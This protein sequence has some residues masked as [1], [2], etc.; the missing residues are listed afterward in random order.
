LILWF[1]G[2]ACLMV[3]FVFRE[4][5]IDYRLVIAGALLPD[6]VDGVWGGARL[7]HTLVFSVVLMFAVMAATRGRSARVRRRRR[8]WLAV[9][10]GTFLHL[11]LDGMWVRTHVFWWPFFGWSFEGARLPTLD[12]PVWV[13]ALQEA[14]GL[15]ALVWYVGQRR[16]ALADASVEPPEAPSC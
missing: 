11:V 2:G 16:A 1:A 14:A 4:P 9:P 6:L 5:R 10:I 15:A 13:V 3:W 12:R 8:Q 7:L